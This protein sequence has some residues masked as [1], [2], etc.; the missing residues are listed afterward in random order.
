MRYFLILFALLNNGTLLSAANIQVTKD[1]ET[2]W[3][4]FTLSHG[5][6]VVKIVP[7]AGANVMSIQEGGV[8]FFHQPKKLSDL[9]GVGYGNPILYPMPNRV[10][11]AKF[12]F[13][14]QDFNFPANGRGNFIHGLVNRQPFDVERMKVADDKVALTLSV[15]FDQVDSLKELFPVAHKFY[16]TITVSAGRVRWEYKVENNEE[17]KR[18]PFGVALHPYFVYQGERSETYL[19]IP[20]THLMKSERQLPSGELIAA[21]DLDYALK[22]PLCM[23]SLKLDDVF[24]GL[25]NEKTT[26]IDFR[27]KKRQVT[28]HASDEFTHLVVWTPDRPYFG[29]ESQTCSTDAHNL[30]AAGKKEVAHLQ[31]CDPGKSMTGWVEYE[32]KIDTE[33]DDPAE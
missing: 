23:A 10:K 21:A 5:A 7:A 17:S 30:H 24:F 16:M 6:T 2:G 26:L 27:D 1:E 25:S 19:T 4:I 14:D 32:L 11:G 15:D 13:D 33:K 22:E 9:P 3:K 20:A 8:E 18:L 12:T 29:V 28:I 31:I